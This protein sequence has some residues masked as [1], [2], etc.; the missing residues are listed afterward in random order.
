MR[1]KR[2]K[3]PI[4]SLRCNWRTN[5]A[6]ANVQAGAQTN[7]ENGVS[8]VPVADGN[9]AH[10]NSIVPEEMAQAMLA[11]LTFQVQSMQREAAGLVQLTLAFIKSKSMTVQAP[12][13]PPQGNNAG[14]GNSKGQEMYRGQQRSS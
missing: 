14:S 11:G 12:Q 13:S 10:S 3:M 5:V 4:R 8:L 6:L 7:K 2:R 9:I 1:N